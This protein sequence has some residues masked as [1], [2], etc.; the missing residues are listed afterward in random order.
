MP[1]THRSA[2]TFAALV[3]MRIASS[4]LYAIT[5]IITLS[6]SCPCSAAIATV[7]SSPITWKQTWFTI[8]GID[9]LILPGMIDEPGCTAGS[10]ISSMPVRGPITMQAQVA[11]DLAQVDR[12]HAQRGAER[13][14]RRPCSA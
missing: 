14:R 4:T 2:S 11:R 1:F 5:G 12:E 10:V 13:R 7:V 8:S 3:R 9:G 6:S